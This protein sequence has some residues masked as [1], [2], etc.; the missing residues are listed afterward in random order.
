[1]PSI[2]ES[3]GHG[4]GDVEEDS[5][6]ERLSQLTIPPNRDPLESGARPSVVLASGEKTKA[7]SSKHCQPQLT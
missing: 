2:A 7:P 5:L 1:M 3:H 4:T 6:A